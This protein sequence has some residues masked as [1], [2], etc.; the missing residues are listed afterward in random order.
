MASSETKGDSN[1]VRGTGDEPFWRCLTL[2][3]MSSEQWE[4]LCD[5]CGRCCLNKLEDEDTGEISW[6]TIRCR[7][8]DGTA[9]RC[10]DYDNRSAIVPDCVRLT[11]Q[12][13]RTLSWLPPSC[14]YRRLAEGDDLCWWHP[15]VS[16]DAE[17]VFLAG[18]SVAGRTVS[19]RVVPLPKWEEYVVDWPAAP[20]GDC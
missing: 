1:P 18:I 5:G 17:T 14:A 13:V 7:L 15:L 9:C 10:T 19:E 20:P 6:T 4:S 8:L 11:P 12:N 2:E 16:G 3:E